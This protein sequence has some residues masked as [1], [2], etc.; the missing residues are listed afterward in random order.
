MVTLRSFLTRRTITLSGRINVCPW[1]C[2]AFTLIKA[3]NGTWTI[4]ILIWKIIR[5]LH[6]SNLRGTWDLSS[7]KFFFF[8]NSGLKSLV[9]QRV[10]AGWVGGV[11]FYPT[12]SLEQGMTPISLIEGCSLLQFDFGTGLIFSYNPWWV[13]I[14]L[15]GEY[16]S[17]PWTREVQTSQTGNG[18]VTLPQFNLNR[19]KY[20]PFVIFLFYSELKTSLKYTATNRHKLHQTGKFSLVSDRGRIVV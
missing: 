14:K 1:V 17:K 9:E 12:D 8:F 11:G 16:V 3:I 7:F 2:A 18:S 6:Y 4:N 19:C 20:P 10:R 5:T 13:L 15:W